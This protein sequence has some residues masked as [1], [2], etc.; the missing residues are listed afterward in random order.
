MRKVFGLRGLP[1]EQW[2]RLYLIFDW[3]TIPRGVD[4]GLLAREAIEGGA[5]MV[6]FRDKATEPLDAWLAHARP[7]RSV[8]REFGIPFVVND[9]IDAVEPLEAD[10]LHLGQED[11]ALSNA[12]TLVGGD[13]LIGISTH[14]VAQA[15][16]AAE[17][18]ADY[19]GIGAMFPT[20]IKPDRQPVGIS[21]LRQVARA[22]DIPVYPI[23]GIG[24]SN[25]DL[26]TSAGIGR[27]AVISAIMQAKDPRL[28]ASQLLER[29]SS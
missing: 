7:V 23:G 6:Q 11:L 1:V 19:L 10:G 21:M 2:P 3:A 14:D 5:G 8:C 16:E 17:M 4:P 28:A 27:C 12:R 13:V 26:I 9:R 20:Q 18:G 29:L 24:L 15:R 22:V 25:V